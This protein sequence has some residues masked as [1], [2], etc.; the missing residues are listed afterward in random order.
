MDELLMRLKIGPFSYVP[1]DATVATQGFPGRVTWENQGSL[2]GKRKDKSMTMR[3]KAQ[4][5]WATGIGA[6]M[7]TALLVSAIGWSCLTAGEAKS[8]VDVHIAG[9]D[10]RHAAI[11][12]EFEDAESHRLRI[13]VKIDQQNDRGAP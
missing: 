9:D 8:K 2:Q 1:D 10:E 12:R 11:M 3:Q 7:L 13:E 4:L 5:R 6:A